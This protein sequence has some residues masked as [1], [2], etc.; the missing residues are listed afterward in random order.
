MYIV[1]ISIVAPLIVPFEFDEA[2]YYGESV[3]VTCHI[4]KGDKPLKLSWNFH[5]K[6]MSSH[7]G[8]VT[9]KVGDRSSILTISSV[10]AS[11]S[12]N[13]TCTASNPVSTVSYTTVLNVKGKNV[14]G[15][16]NL[17]PRDYISFIIP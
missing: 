17:T 7:L 8:I 10:M 11:H 12:G 16:L 1:E 15:C 13:Y 5:G 3:Q 2:V 4:S 6:E 14:F 9:T